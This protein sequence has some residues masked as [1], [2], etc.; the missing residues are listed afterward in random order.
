MAINNVYAFLC[1]GGWIYSSTLIVIVCSY[2]WISWYTKTKSFQTADRR[3]SRDHQRP[4]RE[5]R[6]YFRLLALITVLFAMGIWYVV[7]FILSIANHLSIGPPYADRICYVSIIAGYGI[8][9]VLSLMFTDDVRRIAFSSKPLVFF[10]FQRRQQ[11]RRI[12]CVTV[13]TVQ[14]IPTKHETTVWHESLFRFFVCENHFFL[15]VQTF[16]VQILSSVCSMSNEDAFPTTTPIKNEWV[17]SMIVSHYWRV[18]QCDLFV[19]KVLVREST[20]VGCETINGNR[21]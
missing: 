20:S 10:G 21:F 17:N 18:V 6:L 13:H 7:F 16:F 19:G 11:A 5:I 4:K 12:G 8:S 2:A 14:P 9:M 3:K 1:T 15:F